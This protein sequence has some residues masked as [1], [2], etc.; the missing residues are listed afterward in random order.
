LGIRISYISRPHQNTPDYDSASLPL[1]RIA[2][3]NT[4]L[5]C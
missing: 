2:V 5:V 4:K 3:G 1:P